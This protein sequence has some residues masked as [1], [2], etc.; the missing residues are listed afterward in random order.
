M[1]VWPGNYTAY[2]IA[3]ELELKRQ[4][5]TYQAQRK[6]IERLEEA[7]RRLIQWARAVPASQSNKA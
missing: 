1:R 5:E 4:Q 6:E 3:R 7:S 2:A